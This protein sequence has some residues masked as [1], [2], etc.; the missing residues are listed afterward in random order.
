MTVNPL[1]ESDATVRLR[2]DDRAL[3]ASDMHLAGHDPATVTAFIEALNRHGTGATHL[4]LLGDL[5]DL[6]VG[7]DNHDAV[8]DALGGCLER[9][10]DGGREV[11]LMRG[12][13]DF[14][15]DTG[16]PTFSERHHARLL[17]D[18]CLIELFGERV[19]LAH[20]DALCIDDLDYQRARALARS[21]GWQ[22]DFLA[23]PLDERLRIAGELRGESRRVQAARAMGD[24]D[25][26]DVTPEAV[27]AAMRS[28]GVRTMVHGHTHR[29][30]CH[31]WA[32]DGAPALR[33]VLPDWHAGSDGSS[34]G[35]F[36]RV[37][38]SGW[39]P[40]GYPIGDT[41]DDSIGR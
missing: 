15:I 22:R 29:P 35:G 1:R 9:L 36:L 18:P 21:D 14:L 3:F 4:F 19:L 32:L 2:G 27:D 25:P 33:W 34:R 30:A 16:T 17:P 37:D 31:R 41:A 6:W 26:G 28:A 12:N 8:A 40:I 24:T 7:D 11:W 5:F 10:A 39:S 20:G 13:R 38:V 23:R